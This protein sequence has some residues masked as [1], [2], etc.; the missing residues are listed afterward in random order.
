MKLS[1]LTLSLLSLSLVTSCSPKSS[2]FSDLKMVAGNYFSIRQQL[3]TTY[4][5]IVKLKS[6]P[7]LETAIIENGKTVIDEDAKKAL[8]DEQAEI[9]EKL[10]T[11]SSDIKIV[12][13]YKMVLNAIAFTAPS[14]LAAKI[15][16]L[17]GVA[18]LEESSSFLRP[19]TVGLNE[20]VEKA[21]EGLNE[22]NTVT[23]IGADKLHQAGVS[24]QNM[25]VGVI[26][27]G[28]DYT[29]NMFGG[30]GTKEA[31]EA[32]DPSTKNEFFPNAKVVGGA[33]FVGSKYSAGG[34][35]LEEQVPVRDENPIDESGHGSHV[36]GSVAGLGDGKV[37]YSGVAPDAAIYALKVFGK[38]GSTSD[39]AVIQALEYAADPTEKLNP[40][41]RLDVV[42]LSLGGGFG[43]PKILYNEAI[44]NLTKAGTVVVA[45]AGNSGDTPYI[46]GAPGTSDAAISVAA[47]ID[48]M[49][50]NISVPAV[51]LSVGGSKKL[52]EKV[53]GNNTLPAETSQVS[54]ALVAIGNGVDVISE[55]VK[56]S[57][58]GKIALMDR[59]AISFEQKFKV[60]KA[61]EAV[62]VVMVNNVDATP[63]PMGS[64]EKFNFPAIMISK[65]LGTAI[66]EALLKKEDVV[67]DFSPG[68]SI[69]RDDLI[70]TMTNFSSR[71]P[72]SIDSL[73][74]PEISGPGANVISA[75]FGTGNETVQFSGTSMSGPHL[76]GVMALL[77][78]A[79][80]KEDVATLK[81][82][83]LNNAKIMMKDGK[84]V[85]VSRQGAGR[86]QV[87]EAFKAK[88]IVMPA[89]LSLGE[90]PV[91]STKTIKKD[92]TLNN[93]SDKDVLFTSKVLRSANIQVSVQ[94]SLKVKAK[95]SLKIPVSFTLKRENAE[96]DNIEADGFVVFTNADDA[97]KISLPFLAVLN[98][99][100]DIK[101][102]D[103]VVQTDSKVDMDG[104]EVK[105]TLTNSSKSSG[106]ALI[107]NLLGTDEKRAIPET[108]LS[109]STN[110]DL[111][112]A[113]I[114]IVEKTQ[115][116]VTVKV[117]QVGVKLHEAMTMW[118]PCD[119]SLQID[120]NNDGVADQELLGIKANY[121]SGIKSEAFA[122]I[123]LDAELARSLR[124]AFELGQVTEENYLPAILDAREMKFYNHSNVAI[125]ETELSKILKG[126]NGQV[127]IKLS[128]THLEADTKADDFLASHGEKWQKLNL[129][130][131]ALA[132]Y[133]MPEVVTV[134]ENDLEHVSMRRGLGKMR[135]LVLYPH[136]SP[137]ALKDKQSQILTEKLLK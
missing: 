29:H 43:K 90:V 64:E 137:T 76:A 97:S 79:H 131:N 107:F 68:Q 117:L 72:R 10:T 132:Y 82:R 33:D 125:V 95:S 26:D 25:R 126:K 114:R 75:S 81:A 96:Q 122:S 128:V 105:L 52:I 121:V 89:T 16:V 15:E 28:V 108:N 12:A 70:D 109:T 9:I 50:Q 73:I 47:S 13:T 127:G 27:T 18:K 71:G 84:H 41:N 66:K 44:H 8:L 45:S 37:S 99:V 83:L 85:S 57:V 56:A 120:S 100:S 54:G 86:V 80:P 63:I 102:S 17:E 135:A 53:E 61:L 65:S 116:N 42:N 48:Y 30:A 136:N 38:K 92:I 49:P 133:E 4:I 130:E 5:G 94:G 119:V 35:T 112:A 24:G 19:E 22:K 118:Q 40:E 2:T 1:V 103:L 93:T 110:C 123:L 55:E 39:I 7:L 3:P 58:K 74:K 113:G 106:D 60:A 21:L 129:T 101:A 46:T 20:K 51:S 69:N 36:A 98:K 23:F 14:E 59:G 124:T 111:E 11:L 77:K 31:Y 87:E 88:V 115:N 104:S 78:Q 91:A 34:A 67:F 62:G 6:A 134:K 32:I